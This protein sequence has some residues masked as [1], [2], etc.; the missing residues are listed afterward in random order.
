MTQAEAQGRPSVALISTRTVRAGR[1]H[2]SGTRR[3]VERLL[4]DAAIRVALL[5]FVVWTLAPVAWMIISSLLNQVALTSVPPDLS[6]GQL[7]LDNYRG[8]LATG[9]S[10][11]PALKNSLLISLL[12][13]GIALALVFI[14]LLKPGA[15]RSQARV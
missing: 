1:T 8:V 2:K 9:Q 3:R 11:V 15:P 6:L 14:K 13:T 4:A 7:T 12:T 10:L 5:V